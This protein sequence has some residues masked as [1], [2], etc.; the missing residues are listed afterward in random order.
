MVGW[1][2]L[3]RDC[4]GVGGCGDGN[5]VSVAVHWGLGVLWGRSK[6]T[7]GEGGAGHCL[8]SC[9]VGGGEGEGR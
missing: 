1:L 9:V 3:W 8:G 6:A 4:L 5:W 7:G 2:G